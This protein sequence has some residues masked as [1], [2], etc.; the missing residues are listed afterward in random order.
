MRFKVKVDREN[1]EPIY[2][3]FSHASAACDFIEKFKAIN[4]HAKL[5]M[6]INGI[7]LA[8]FKV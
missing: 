5:T 6:Y 2:R 4:L 1:K 8:E 7:K 3:E